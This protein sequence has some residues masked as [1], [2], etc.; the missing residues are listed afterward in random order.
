MVLN[1]QFKTPENKTKLYQKIIPI[2]NSNYLPTIGLINYW[3]FNQNFF[4][5]I[6]GNDLYNGYNAVLASDK[7]NK[8]QSALSITNGYYKIPSG[9]YFSGEHTVMVWIKPKSFKLV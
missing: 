8:V 5:F 3:T 9:V 4:D 6:G 1:Y 2:L 7:S